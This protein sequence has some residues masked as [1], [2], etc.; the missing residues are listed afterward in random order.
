MTNNKVGMLS[1]HESLSFG[2]TLQCFALQKV[3]RDMGYDPE[4]IDFQRKKCAEF[5]SLKT[6]PS[7]KERLKQHVIRLILGVQNIIQSKN[8]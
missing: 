5:K 7:T 8:R 2:A 1:F 3:V 6:Q 4:F